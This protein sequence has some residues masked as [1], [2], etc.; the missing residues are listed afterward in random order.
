M[1]LLEAGNAVQIHTS[2]GEL[3]RRNPL[4][5]QKVEFSIG[6]AFGFGHHEVR[7]QE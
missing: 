6:A 2:L 5:K 3:R 1:F 7:E 4:L